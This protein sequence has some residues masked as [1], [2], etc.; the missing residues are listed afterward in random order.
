MRADQASRFESFHNQPFSILCHKQ[1]FELSYEL[2]LPP[3]T[4]TMRASAFLARVGLLSSSAVQASSDFDFNDAIAASGLIGSQFGVPGI[5]GQYDYLILGGGTAGLTMAKRLAEDKRFTVAVVEAGDFYEFAN[6]NNT[7]I[8]C[9]ISSLGT[10]LDM[11]HASNCFL[12][13]Q[14]QPHS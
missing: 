1:Y 9:V 10:K 12:L 5:P 13:G 4:L 14:W 7:Q 6:G 8:P 11:F 2:C 3:S